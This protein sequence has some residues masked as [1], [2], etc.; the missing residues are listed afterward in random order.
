MSFFTIDLI[1]KRYESEK[2]GKK[3]TT[4][5][6]ENIYMCSVYFSSG[7]VSRLISKWKKKK[8]KRNDKQDILICIE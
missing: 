4:K 7:D 2:W 6:I 8:K 1:T 5:L 3:E